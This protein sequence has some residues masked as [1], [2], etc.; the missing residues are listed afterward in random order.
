MSDW[1][2][3][4]EELRQ[5]ADYDLTSEIAIEEAKEALDN[6]HEFYSFTKTYLEKL[7]ADS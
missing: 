1:A 3:K 6:A 2:K 4:S 5:S 7:I